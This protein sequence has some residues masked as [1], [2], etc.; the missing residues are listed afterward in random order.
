MAG[1]DQQNARSATNA[2]KIKAR[3]M[4][5]ENP[6]NFTIRM[7]LRREYVQKFPHYAETG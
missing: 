2:K 6:L 7:A 5:V 4:K 3:F 1:E